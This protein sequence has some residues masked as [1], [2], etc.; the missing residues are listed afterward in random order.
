MQPIGLPAV[1]HQEVYQ[2]RGA[3][4]GTARVQ[5]AQVR[6]GG[7][8]GPCQQLC[9][10]GAGGPASLCLGV[11]RST[12][13]ASS[14][15]RSRQGGERHMP[16]MWCLP[17]DP[18]VSRAKVA[19]P[20]AAQSCPCS[21]CH[22]SAPSCY[23]RFAPPSHA[24]AEARIRS[25]LSLRSPHMASTQQQQQ[26]QQQWQNRRRVQ[27]QRKHLHSTE[28][29]MRH[30]RAQRPYRQVG[31]KVE[32]RQHCVDGSRAVDSCHRR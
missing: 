29:G 25:H 18:T 9:G 22:Y 5:L 27:Q 6:E 8:A 28:H 23:R 26:Q 12:V 20:A 15:A 16:G 19:S 14:Q 7:G 17:G 10:R 31:P 2:L 11:L 24:A 30:V 32:Q 1:V 13:G 4:A 3:A 21:C